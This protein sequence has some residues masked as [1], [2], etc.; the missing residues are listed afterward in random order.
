MPIVK[1]YKAEVISVVNPAENIYTAEF[2]SCTGTFKYLPGQFLHLALEEYDP[3]SSWPE[4]RCFSMQSPPNQTTLKITWS[5][6]GLFTKRMAEELIPGKII[7]IKLP[8]GELFQQE[9]NKKNVVFIAGGTGITPFLSAFTDPNFS[10][11]SDPKLYFGI[12]EKKF[13]IYSEEF[14]I[15][16]SIN[17]DLKII[18]CYQDKD[19]MIDILKIL[20][21]N[22]IQSTYFISGP[23]LMISNFKKELIN[24]G[25][26]PGKIKTDEWE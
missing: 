17:P 1:K 19:G 5:V 26:N 4:S 6:K 22:G 16:R 3:S 8:F 14:E 23:Q 15:A 7:D 10:E 9:H 20:E 2:K 13:H 12:R 11:Y 24:Q 18:E 21:E 25:V